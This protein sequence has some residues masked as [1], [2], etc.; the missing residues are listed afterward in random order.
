ME[1]SFVTSE[2][3]WPR[4]WVSHAVDHVVP[5]VV[6]TGELDRVLG[7]GLCVDVEVETPQAAFQLPQFPGILKAA[8]LLDDQIGGGLLGIIDTNV[9]YLMSKTAHNDQSHPEH[10]C[11]ALAPQP[12]VAYA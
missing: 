9:Q 12:S 2:D 11:R 5:S 7:K 10:A 6:K 4:A 3:T 8:D 1:P